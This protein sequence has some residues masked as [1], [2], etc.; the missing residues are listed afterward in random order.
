MIK[1]LSCTKTVIVFL[2]V[3]MVSLGA[4]MYMFTRPMSYGMEYYHKTVYE[5]ERFE[6]TMIFRSDGT[7]VTRNT[8]FE[9]DIDSRYYYKDGYVFFTM[10]Q[11]DAEYEEEVAYINDHF[12]EAIQST[13]Y[14]AK[15][16]TF[17]VVTEGPDG[18]TSV[19]TCTSAIV[20]A[21]VGGVVELALIVLTAITLMLS[22]KA[23]GKR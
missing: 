8:T 7:M 2:I 11:T 1:L 12:E 5:G 14:A 23:K 9:E 18:Y 19:Y 3:M 15:A 13:F 21:V 22:R 10:A 4:Y 17:R 16:D 6:C 20:W